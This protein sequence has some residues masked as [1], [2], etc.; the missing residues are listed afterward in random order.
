MG[1]DDGSFFQHPTPIVSLYSKS[2][3]WGEAIYSEIAPQTLS[4]INNAVLIYLKLYLDLLCDMKMV[5]TETRNKM[6][7][8]YFCS[9]KVNPLN[10]SNPMRFTG[11]TNVACCGI[12]VIYISIILNI[13]I[14]RCKKI[15]KIQILPIHDLL[16]YTAEKVE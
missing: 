3:L 15:S 16:I 10:I 1:V 11:S 12:A 2:Q 14:Q 6:R 4:R 8:R 5:N 13:F 7:N 9:H